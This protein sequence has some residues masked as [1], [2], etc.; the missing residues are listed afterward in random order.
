MVSSFYHCIL[1]LCLWARQSASPPVCTLLFLSI[2]EQTKESG[3]YYSKNSIYSYCKGASLRYKKGL[4][5][6]KKGIIKVECG[7]LWVVAADRQNRCGVQSHYGAFEGERGC[8]CT[9]GSG[10]KRSQHF[11]FLRPAHSLSA[12][13]HYHH[14]SGRTQTGMKLKSAGVHVKPSF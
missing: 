14:E 10:E 9:R 4:W 5:P 13:R 2:F 8:T 6:K 7:A 12:G 1:L 11:V 3:Q